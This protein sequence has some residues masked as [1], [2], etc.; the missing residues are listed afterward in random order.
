MYSS[1]PEGSLLL[2][3]GMVAAV[4]KGKCND[5]VL[6][7]IWQSKQRRQQVAWAPLTIAIYTEPGVHEV[8]QHWCKLTK[9]LWFN[10]G[11]M[12]TY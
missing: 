7:I 8:Q 3:F 5:N 11:D 6:E 9:P 1:G 12:S 10:L 4:F 2:K